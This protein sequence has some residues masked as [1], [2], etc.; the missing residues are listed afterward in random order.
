MLRL[1]TALSTAALVS[2]CGIVTGEHGFFVSSPGRFS[3][4]SCEELTKRYAAALEAEKKHVSVM[5]RVMEDPAGF[6]VNFFVYSSPLASQRGELHRL[7]EQAK[8]SN[9]DLPDPNIAAAASPG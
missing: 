5:E 1:I 9:C 2:A 3:H 8:A 7:E 6:F 4:L